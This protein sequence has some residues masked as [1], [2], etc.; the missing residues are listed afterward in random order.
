MKNVLL[1]Q[2]GEREQY[3]LKMS[4][5]G[6]GN[7]P[8]QKRRKKHDRWNTISGPRLDLLLE[9]EKHLKDYFGVK[10]ITVNYNF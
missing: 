10:F 2:K 1:G 4:K 3:S 6:Y 9:K 7:V 5:K 8:D